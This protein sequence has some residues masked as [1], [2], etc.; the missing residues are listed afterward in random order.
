MLL[1]PLN[2]GLLRERGVFLHCLETRGSAVLLEAHLDSQAV[3]ALQK[4][5]ALL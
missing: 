5:N 2:Q 3:H 1:E 4:H